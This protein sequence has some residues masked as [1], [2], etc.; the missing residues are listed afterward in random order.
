MAEI[1]LVRMAKSKLILDIDFDFTM[2][3]ISCHYLDYRLC[4]HIN[5]NLRVQLKKENDYELTKSKRPSDFFSFYKFDNE[6]RQLSYIFI[7]NKGL[8]SYLIKEHQNFDYFLIVEGYLDE[9]EQIKILD[10]IKKIPIVLIATQI[11]PNTL[12]SKHNLIFE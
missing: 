3:A 2:Y 9:A 4:W 5:K 11:D 12:P 6:N 1:F 8:Q 7:S 10:H